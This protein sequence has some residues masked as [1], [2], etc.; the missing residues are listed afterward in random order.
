LGKAIRSHNAGEQVAV[1]IIRE[2]K[3]MTVGVTLGA[4]PSDLGRR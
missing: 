2:G 4:V 1:T 3:E